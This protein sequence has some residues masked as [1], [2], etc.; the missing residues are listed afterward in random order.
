V[1]IQH[2]NNV[3][4][5]LRRDFSSLILGD[6]ETLH[7]EWVGNLDIMFLD[8]WPWITVWQREHWKCSTFTY[9]SKNC[10][11]SLLQI[12]HFVVQDFWRDSFQRIQA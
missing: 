7:L 5:N 4:F 1:H 2:V 10:H 6:F 9:T 12:F 11:C 8:E 3:F